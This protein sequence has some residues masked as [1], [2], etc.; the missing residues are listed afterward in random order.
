LEASNALKCEHLTIIN[1]NLYE[2]RNVQGKTIRFIPI[3][4][5]LTIT[6]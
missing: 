5:W 2:E 6:P 1:E 3:I 4:D